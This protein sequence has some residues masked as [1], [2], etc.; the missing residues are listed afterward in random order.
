[1]KIWRLAFGD[2]LVSIRMLPALVGAAAVLLTGLLTI[3][4]GG[5]GLAVVL[6]SLA[7][8]V[9]GQYLNTAHYYSMNVFDQLFLVLTAYVALRPLGEGRPRVWVLLGVTLGLGLL[10][11]TSVLWLGAG[12]MVGLAATPARDVLRTRWP[13]VAGAV[14]LVLFSPYLIWE[15]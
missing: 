6:A 8:L 11:K 7:V 3:E 14:A 12:L 10:N 9:A 2:S 4:L 5:G 15:I 13:Y 1:L